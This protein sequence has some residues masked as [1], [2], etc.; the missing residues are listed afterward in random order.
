MFNHLFHLMILKFSSTRHFINRYKCLTVHNLQTG[1]HYKFLA[2]QLSC[3]RCNKISVSYYTQYHVPECGQELRD[4]LKIKNKSDFILLLYDMQ[5]NKEV[6]R[7]FYNNMI[8]DPRILFFVQVTC[9][10]LGNSYP[11]QIIF[12]V[13]SIAQ[14]FAASQNSEL[15]NICVTK[16]NDNRKKV[17]NLNVQ[18]TVS[19]ST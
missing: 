3:V 2:C 9:F 17:V 18:V 13:L 16:T 14:N 1:P 10:E 6:F 4:A 19:Q 7:D 12:Y 8:L 11:F 15:I 5:I